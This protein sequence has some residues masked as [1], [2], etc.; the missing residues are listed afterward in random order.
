LSNGVTERLGH[1]FKEH[2]IHTS[3][4]EEKITSAMAMSPRFYSYKKYLNQYV[5]SLNNNRPL[6]FPVTLLLGTLVELL[7]FIG[8]F[9]EPP[10][11][12]MLSP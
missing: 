12:S 10:R 5:K 7:G 9:P 8:L 1:T 4:I 3:T 11:T 6:D 2:K